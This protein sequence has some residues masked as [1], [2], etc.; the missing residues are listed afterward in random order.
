MAELQFCCIKMGEA[1]LLDCDLHDD[2]AECPDVL[3][4]QRVSGEYGIWVH[5]GSGSWIGIEYCPWCGVE[6]VQQQDAVVA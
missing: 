2:S 5:D 1:V 6:L 4:K 3:I